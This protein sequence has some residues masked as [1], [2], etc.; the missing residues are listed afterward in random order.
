[1]PRFVF[2]LPG[3][4][5]FLLGW[6]LSSRAQIQ[7]IAF[8]LI[9]EKTS[10]DFGTMGELGGLVYHSFT[11]QNTS[12]DTVWMQNASA[13]CHCTKGE[14]PLEGIPPKGTG[15]IKVTYDPKGRPWEF[16]TGVE[17]KLKGFAK[18]KELKVKGNTIRGAETIRFEPAEY[19]QRFQYN[20]KS[21]EAEEAEFMAFV[22]KMVPLIEKHKNIKI[23]IESSASYVPTKSFANNTELTMQR[24]KDA[25]SKMLDI[26]VKS[27]ADLSRVLFE[28]D[29]TKVQGP[30]YSKDY[31]SQMAKY[32]PFQYVKIRVF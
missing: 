26:L 17:V 23:Q 6:N 27:N 19:T 21:I 9:F 4:F 22:E 29:L 11:F 24:A 20:E 12:K 1:M 28:E 3:L 18:T 2:Q 7:E 16:E 31:K 30:A 14:F 13:S 25:R 8:P 15:T 10:F 32:I 5:V